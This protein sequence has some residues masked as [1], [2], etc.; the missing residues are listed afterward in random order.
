MVL[1]NGTVETVSTHDIKRLKVE[2]APIQETLEGIL[3]T[4]T[5]SVP[6]KKPIRPEGLISKKIE[7]KSE[8]EKAKEAKAREYK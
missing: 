8:A 1:I 6:K 3:N 4:S 5:S 7:E 2:N